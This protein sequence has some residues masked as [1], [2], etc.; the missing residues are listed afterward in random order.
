MA[1]MHYPMLYL[2]YAAGADTIVGDVSRP[3]TAKH[4]RTLAA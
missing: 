3:K 1:N 2:L 4:K